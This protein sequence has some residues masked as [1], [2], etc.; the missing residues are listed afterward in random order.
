MKLDTTGT[1][2]KG[3]EEGVLLWQLAERKRVLGIRTTARIATTLHLFLYVWQL[4]LAANEGRR[5][6]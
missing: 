5:Q 4:K 2:D 1:S 3:G 6:Q